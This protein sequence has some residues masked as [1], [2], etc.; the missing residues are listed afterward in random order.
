MRTLLGRA[1]LLV[2][3]SLGLPPDGRSDLLDVPAPLLLGRDAA[4]EGPAILATAFSPDSKTLA[5]GGKDKVIRLWDVRTGRELR[6]LE[7]HRDWVSSVSFSGD[8]K[9]LASASRDWTVRLWERSTGAAVRV[10]HGHQAGVLSVA[11]APNGRAL[12]SGSQDGTL[13]TWDV[14]TGVESFR[15]LKE[16]DW[17]TAVAYSP[18]GD[19]LA[20]AGWSGTMRLQDAASLREL[21]RLGK[22][23]GRFIGV[24]WLANDTL[25]ALTQNK[26]LCR[27]EATTGRELRINGVSERLA[28]LAVTPDG[29]LLAAG[30]KDGTI[31]LWETGTE[32]EL[33]PLGERWSAVE[34][35]GLSPDGKHLAAGSSSTRIWDLSGLRHS[36]RP[37]DLTHVELDTLWTALAGEDAPRAH[38]AM[39]LLEQQPRLA[40]PLLRDRLKPV[41]TDSVWIARLV[42]DLGDSK[43]QV[44]QRAM[45]ELERIG[46]FAETALREK[47]REKPALEVRQRAAMLLDKMDPGP[48]IPYVD[49]AR[50]SRV[51]QIL[52]QFRG[53]EARE[54][55]R[56][57]TQGAPESWLTQAAKQALANLGA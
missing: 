42:D 13:R 28:C 30:S 44:R 8:G 17:V 4:T 36:P 15:S 24:A 5:T 43:F 51:L 1:A 55:L 57:L 49:A 20:S 50:A 45:R 47:L 56:E 3:L 10:L 14:A 29:R 19:R 38:R 9:Y 32:K 41:V 6:R 26:G 31:R 25:V 12:A 39:W 34:C 16:S 33:R 23:H 21:H 2:S 54:H 7:G 46:K 40:L 48:W 22:R 35:M 53:V 18:D 27:W 11:F 52:Q 37:P